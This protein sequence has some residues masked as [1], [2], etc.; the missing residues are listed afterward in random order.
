MVTAECAD[1]LGSVQYA[2]KDFVESVAPNG[3]GSTPGMLGFMFWAAERP[4]TPGHDARRPPEHL[5]DGGIAVVATPLNLTIPMPALR[6]RREGRHRRPSGPA[7]RRRSTGDRDDHPR[8]RGDP[9]WGAALVRPMAA[10]T[11]SRRTGAGSSSAHRAGGSLD[12]GRRRG[13]LGLDPARRPGAGGAGLAALEFNLETLGPDRARELHELYDRFETNHPTGEPHAY[14]SLLAT[15]PDHRGR[16]VGQ[17]LLAEILRSGTR[18]ACRATSSPPTRPTTTGT[19]APASDGSAGSRPSGTTRR[20]RRCGVPSRR[21]EW[22]SPGRRPG[23]DR[24][25]GRATYG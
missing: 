17:A 10:P 12:A 25:R 19:S 6:Q 23:L 21:S 20:S 13:G 3:A 1:F 14:L 16:G 5:A 15:H 8:V 7:G 18:S 24:R 9:V 22:M 4:S 2:T 11:T